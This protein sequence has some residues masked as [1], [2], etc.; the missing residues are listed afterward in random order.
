M[1]GPLGQ[2]GKWG[3]GQGV[4]QHRVGTWGSNPDNQSKGSESMVNSHW[5]QEAVP[6]SKAAGV[7]K[8]GDAFNEAG[9][10]IW[11]SRPSS[12]SIFPNETPYYHANSTVMTLFA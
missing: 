1:L 9:Q 11:V 3:Q 2:L 4:T 8:W 10:G 12:S 7:S 5:T 6:Q